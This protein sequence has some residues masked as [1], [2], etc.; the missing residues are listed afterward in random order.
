MLALPTLR[1]RNIK[2]QM[3]C[4]D[5]GGA[6]GWGPW[7][8][9]AG[10]AVMVATLRDLLLLAHSD[11]LVSHQ[12]SN[13]SRLALELSAARKGRAGPRPRT[14]PQTLNH[15]SHLGWILLPFF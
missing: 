11:F 14:A 15:T 13:L 4:A 12:L 5:G 9:D 10:H 8:W 2:P 7:G 3:R 1:Y 6:R